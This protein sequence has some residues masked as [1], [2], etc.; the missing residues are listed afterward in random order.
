MTVGDRP[1]GAVDL[2]GPL[3]QPTPD[4]LIQVAI[5]AEPA[6]YVARVVLGR[7]RRD[8][9]S[10]CRRVSVVPKSHRAASS[11]C[12]DPSEKATGT[13]TPVWVACVPR[14]HRA[15]HRHDVARCVSQHFLAGATHEQS[16]RPVSTVRADDDQIRLLGHALH[17]GVERRHRA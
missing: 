16:S 14:T 6:L 8:A 15:L 13:R 4:P 12:A 9:C 17:D 1:A 7:N 3:A 10:R 5:Q 11:A 2:A